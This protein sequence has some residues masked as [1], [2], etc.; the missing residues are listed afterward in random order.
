MSEIKILWETGLWSKSNSDE[1]SQNKMNKIKVPQPLFDDLSMYKII[2]PL[3]EILWLI[4]SGAN[5]AQC[6]GINVIEG[7]SVIAYVR[8]KGLLNGIKLEMK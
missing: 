7:E 6:E 3:N 5:F 1:E 8:V 2:N 4:S